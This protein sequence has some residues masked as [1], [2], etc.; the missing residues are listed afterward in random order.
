MLS[1]HEKK[2]AQQAVR[3][4]IKKG[5]LIEARPGVFSVTAFG[6]VADPMRPMT[7][8]TEGAVIQTAVRLLEARGGEILRFIEAFKNSRPKALVGPVSV[9]EE[10][11]RHTAEFFVAGFDKW[12]SW[13]PLVQ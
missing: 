2:L 12:R 8:A 10:W 1:A 5:R 9:D 4:L 11:V 13:R 7:Q 3:N 6:L